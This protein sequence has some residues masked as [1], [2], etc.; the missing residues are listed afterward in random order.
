M[1]L[2]Q[3]RTNPP[4]K[5]FKKWEKQLEGQRGMRDLIS[6]DKLGCNSSHVGSMWEVLLLGKTGN[7]YNLV[8]GN[9]VISPIIN[10]IM[11]H[12]ILSRT[13]EQRRPVIW[14]WCNDHT[15]YCGITWC[16]LAQKDSLLLFNHPKKSG[17]ETAE[18]NFFVPH[19]QTLI[20]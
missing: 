6:S 18:N 2:T 7:C 8:F 4:K 1:H 15:Q 19:D 13:E 5:S 20:Y 12:L 17:C 10:L 11:N 16:T 3:T 9:N 14:L